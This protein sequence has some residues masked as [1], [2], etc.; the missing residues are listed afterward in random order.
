MQDERPAMRV[1]VIGLGVM[2]AGMACHLADVGYA[3][4]VYNR[5]RARAQE[6]APHGVT[7]AATPRD[8]AAASEAVILMLSD[9]HATRA[10]T[11]GPG[12]M[13]A[14]LAP[15]TLV[16][17]MATLAPETTIALAVEVRER[18]GELLDAPVMGS[19]AEAASGQLWILAGGDP[20]TL[21]RARPLLASLAQ[22][23]YYAG[24]VGQG[25]RLKLANNLLGANLVTA[26]AETMALIEACGIDPALYA[27]VLQGS[28]LGTR[29][30][31][32]KANQM[33]A[34]DYA[35]RFSIANEYKDVGLALHLARVLGLHLHQG[36]SV[37]APFK[38]AMEGGMG[39]QDIAA[40]RLLVS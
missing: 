17:Q 7:I 18:G 31:V 19:A 40:L 16:L 13:L 26:L 11:D 27:R 14:G 2:G 36:E 1:A 29:M 24:E 28:N 10:C 15:G 5:T 21:E 22:E 8:A 39:A 12:G 34:G 25:A 37:L 23:V 30:L 4:T 6:L 35:A 9:D 38:E 33:V 3:V 32:G 20:A